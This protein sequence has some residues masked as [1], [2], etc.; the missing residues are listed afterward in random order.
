MRIEGTVVLFLALVLFPLSLY[1]VDL[2]GASRT[3]FQ[4]RESFDDET[5][6]PLFE[7]LDFTLDDFAKE[8]YSF[9][10][11]GWARRDLNNEKSFDQR[12]SNLD[13]QYAYLNLHRDEANAVVNVGRV[14][15]YEGVASESIDGFYSR[16][17]LLHGFG[18][19]AYGG[20]PVETD[21]DKRGGDFIYGTRI[22]REQAGLYR[23]GLSY[24][25]EKNDGDDFRTE[26]GLDLR[27]R[28][29][30]QVE[31]FGRSTFNGETSGWMEHAYSVT[32]LPRE[33]LRIVGELDAVNYKDY[34]A[35]VDTHTTGIFDLNIGVLDPDEELLELGLRGEYKVR[36]ALTVTG[37]FRNYNYNVADS[38]NYYGAGLTYQPTE[39]MGGGGSLYRMDGQSDTRRYYEFRLYAYKTYDKADV[40]V[41]FFNV[42]YDASINGE[43]NGFSASIAG[44][45]TLSE[46]GRLSADVEYASNPTFSTDIRLFVKYLYNFNVSPVKV[47]DF[48][49]PKL[50]LPA[51][52][53][54]GFWKK[55][56]TE[57]VGVAEPSK[58]EKEKK[59]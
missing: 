47:P 43:S 26:T 6:L 2:N 50:S 56:T 18:I 24:L 4:A 55:A 17:D 33:D 57:G 38:S 52:K 59:K 5:Y 54:P 48:K 27:L 37:L 16:S 23:V 46:N 12:S 36:E 58:P 49:A 20:I 28:P 45:Y 14:P 31:L 29:R 32:Y 42:H 41:D 15:V 53:I 44:G 25:K 13:L 1:A 30:E 10:F 40:T 51:W 35:N 19:A 8:E 3:Y 9:H 21:F 39:E 11:G 7:Y 34:F 22:S